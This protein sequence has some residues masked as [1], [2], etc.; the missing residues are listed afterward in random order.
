LGGSL[1]GEGCGQSQHHQQGEVLCRTHRSGKPRC[2]PTAAAA[3]GVPAKVNRPPPRGP[4]P[5]CSARP[6]TLSLFGPPGCL[7]VSRRWRKSLDSGRV[8]ARGRHC[9][10][11]NTLRP[12]PADYPLGRQFMFHGLESAGMSAPARGFPTVLAGG[13][14]PSRQPG[15]H[16]R[17]GWEPALWSGSPK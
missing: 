16:S 5:A 11:R 12:Q 6:Y 17:P 13:S 14:L 15:H 1:G 7:G 9:L 2:G 10:G 3:S 4:P 8:G